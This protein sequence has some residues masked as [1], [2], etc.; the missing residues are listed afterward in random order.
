[1]IVSAGLRWVIDNVT[2]AYQ[3]IAELPN[4]GETTAIEI[5]QGSATALPQLNNG[6]LH[7]VVVDPP[8]SD[9]VQYSEL[10]DFFYVWL[11]RSQVHRHQEW[12]SSL[13]SENSLEAVKN[14]ARFRIGKTSAK[15]A[16][17]AAQ[18]HYQKLMTEV[19]IEAHRVLR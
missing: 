10:A 6:S 17:S 4:S 2:D 5:S 12:F 13:L 19:F 7:A 3:A 18:A 14:D 15:D 9:N 11:K 16:K 1:V 8:Y